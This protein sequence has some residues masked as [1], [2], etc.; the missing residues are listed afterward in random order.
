MNFLN[1][2]R[3]LIQQWRD[4]K[5]DQV[6]SATEMLGLVNSVSN[7]AVAAIQSFESPTE[8][9]DLITDCELLYDEFI[10]P[11]DLEGVANIFEPAVD[12]MIRRQIRP[13]LENLAEELM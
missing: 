2:V 8:L 4:S 11:F 6:I 13:V 5:Q 3:Y 7:L 10:T 12:A 1:D 9:N